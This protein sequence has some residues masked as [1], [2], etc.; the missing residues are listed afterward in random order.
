MSE[1]DSKLTEERE[2]ALRKHVRDF[3]RECGFDIPEPRPGEKRKP[4]KIE[5]VDDNDNV[6]ETVIR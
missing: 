6:I 1:N 4:L 3:L 2:Q 5:I